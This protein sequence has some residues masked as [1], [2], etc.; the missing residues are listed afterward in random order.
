MAGTCY[1]GGG[2]RF[3]VVEGHVNQECKYNW[4]VVG[5]TFRALCERFPPVAVPVT[6]E[7]TRQTRALRKTVADTPACVIGRHRSA[8]TVTGVIL[9]FKLSFKEGALGNMLDN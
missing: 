4:E 3:M 7:T 2:N 6:P 1:G 8:S 5:G 9:Y